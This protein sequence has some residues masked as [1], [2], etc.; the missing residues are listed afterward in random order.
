MFPLVKCDSKRDLLCL[1]AHHWPLQTVPPPASPWRSAVGA[2]TR[3]PRCPSWWASPQWGREQHTC[4]CQSRP[5]TSRCLSLRSAAHCCGSTGEA[6]TGWCL[7]RRSLLHRLSERGGRGACLFWYHF[8]FQDNN[9][10]LLAFSQLPQQP[11]TSDLLTSH[12]YRCKA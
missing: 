6:C 11:F 1:P 10:W 8:V 2:G 3:Q 12:H 4:C 7:A 5:A 9:T